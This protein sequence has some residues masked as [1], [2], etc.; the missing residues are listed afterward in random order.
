LGNTFKQKKDAALRCAGGID[1]FTAG[2]RQLVMFC[3]CG[4]PVKTRAATP[5]DTPISTDNIVCQNNAIG[6][7]GFLLGTNYL[8]LCI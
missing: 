7:A 8:R 1:A 3:P 5:T 4:L 6:G 2:M